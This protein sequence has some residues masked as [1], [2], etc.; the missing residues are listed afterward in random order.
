MHQNIL[1]IPPPLL[2]VAPIPEQSISCIMSGDD[3]SK[4]SSRSHRSA[5]EDEEDDDMEHVAS[6]TGITVAPSLYERPCYFRQTRNRGK[7]IKTVQERYLRDDLGFGC[8]FWDPHASKR[9]KGAENTIGKPRTIASVEALLE[10]LGAS[11]DQSFS[12]SATNSSPTFTLLVI[13]TNVLLHQFD[14]LN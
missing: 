11:T 10:L 13:D 3:H 9:R 12:S 14:V 4:R 7:I 8:C 2:P 1:L 6:R 5:M